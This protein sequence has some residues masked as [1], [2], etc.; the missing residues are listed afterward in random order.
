MV[1]IPKLH[2][3]KPGATVLVSAL[4]ALGAL[5]FSACSSGAAPNAGHSSTTTRTVA[6]ITTNWTTFFK[7]T[8]PAAQREKLLQNGSQFAAFLRAQSK[9]SLGKSVSVK[10]TKVKVTTKTTATVTYTI[11]L[12]GTPQLTGSKGKSILQNGTWK[13]SDTS[14]CAL[15]SLEGTASQVK[16]CA[17]A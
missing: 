12:G 5:L 10:V 7:G 15:L 14:F 6:E 1:R 13:V 4:I 11:L 17:K 3:A 16:A 2:R 8:T 9:T